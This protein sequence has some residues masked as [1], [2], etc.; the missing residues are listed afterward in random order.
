MIRSAPLAF[1]LVVIASL[2]FISCSSPE[3]LYHKA[4]KAAPFDVI[5]VP[6]IPFTN[7]DWSSNIMKDRVMWSYFLYSRGIAS[8][9][10]YS[11]SAV[12]S[13]YVE[14]KIM[15]LYAIRM[16]I[17]DSVVFSETKAE[18][19][20]ENLVYSCRLAEMLGYKK[21]AVATDPFQS[22]S[23]QT[24]A[25]DSRIGVTFIP[26]VKDSLV[27][28]YSDSVIQINPSAAFVTDFVPLPE[29]EST[30]KRIFG[31]LGLNMNR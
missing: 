15:A 24:Y 29:R 30:I 3:K 25:W 2:F 7:Q 17:P 10:I 14:G 16:G 26:I 5:I 20:T 4:R 9:V 1:A 19:S 11:G 28:F 22:A 31:T 12:Y 13:P 8:H 21:I 6:G 18:H 27:S 23:L